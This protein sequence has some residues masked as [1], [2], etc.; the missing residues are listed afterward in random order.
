MFL[1]RVKELLE[2]VTPVE[3]VTAF[4]YVDGKPLSKIKLEK[5]NKG[6]DKERLICHFRSESYN[7]KIEEI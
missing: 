7:A 5:V 3:N 4:V 1:S 2:Y 6:T